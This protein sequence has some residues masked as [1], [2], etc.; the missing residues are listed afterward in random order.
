MDAVNS[1]ASKLWSDA[2]SVIRAKIPER[3]FAQWF[4]GIIPIRMDK[5]KIILGVS[6]DYFE[7]WLGLNYSDVIADGL[8]EAAGKPIKFELEPGHQAEIAAIRAESASEPEAEAA[9]APCFEEEDLQKEEN[10]AA[11]PGCAPNCLAS[12]TFDNFIV[13]EENRY[14]YSAALTAAQEPGK[15][16][17]L[18]IYGSTGMGKT[19]LLQAVAN[20]VHRRNPKAIVRYITCE[21]FLNS[22]LDSLRTHSTF[23]SHFEFRNHFREVDVLLVDDVHQLGGKDQIQE[24]FFNTFNTLYN[25][26]KQIILTSDKQPSEI[27]GLEGRLVSRFESG[28]TTQITSPTTFETRLSILQYEQKDQLIKLPP[29]VIHYVAERISSSIRTLK[30]AL[31]RLVAYSSMLGRAVPMAEAEGILSDMLDKEAETRKVTVDRIQQ[32]VAEQFQ[33]RVSDLTGNKRPKNIAEP[34]MMA[35]YFAREMTELSLMDIGNAFGGRN[36]ATVLHAVAQVKKL[37]ESSDDFRRNLST[38]KRKIQG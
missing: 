30:G 19:H 20:F 25:A 32:V 6:D 12:Y 18:Y 35:M 10:A 24:E 33:L 15:F 1:D 14:A 29:D 11:D 22:Y 23:K 2:C 4:E 34:R 38:L 9:P 7:Q 27:R 31:M 37:S 26:G 21:A 36:H 5:K 17:P 3:V 13:G 16:N 8:L 28:V